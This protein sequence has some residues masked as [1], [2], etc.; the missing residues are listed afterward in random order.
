MQKEEI[1]FELSKKVADEM[2]ERSLGETASVDL[3][4]PAFKE[5]SILVSHA[6]MFE[7]ESALKM[8]QNKGVKDL[9]KARQ[10]LIDLKL[11]LDV[12]IH[13]MQVKIKVSY[14]VREEAVILDCT[15]PVALFPM[16]VINKSQLDDQ[17]EFRAIQCYKLVLF[18]LKQ[19]DSTNYEPVVNTKFL[20]APKGNKK[21]NKKGKKNK[22]VKYLVTKKYIIDSIKTE[23]KEREYT[24]PSWAVKG[25]WRKYKSGK[26]VWIEPS[27]RKRKNLTISGEH[28]PTIVKIN[29]TIN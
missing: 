6:S 26:K 16:P 12:K 23:P 19:L 9:V 14:K 7:I 15:F 2:I 1:I 27:T 29:H 21:K 4:H 22:Y 13:D 24:K 3:E 11:K 18:T 5:F 17:S 28:E 8:M 25:Y 10:K 20:D